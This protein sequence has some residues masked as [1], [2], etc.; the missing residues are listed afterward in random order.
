ML[1]A[2]QSTAVCIRNRKICLGQVKRNANLCPA[3]RWYSQN[4][5][6][7]EEVIVEK[8]E[9]FTGFP[10]LTFRLAAEMQNV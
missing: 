2:I 10:N 4:T 5:I 8:L 6:S 3:Q 7:Y 9:T 1:R